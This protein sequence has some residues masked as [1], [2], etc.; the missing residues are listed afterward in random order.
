M[1]MGSKTLKQKSILI[2]G[3]SSE[4]LNVLLKDNTTGSNIIWA[5]VADRVKNSF[6]DY[7]IILKHLWSVIDS[8]PLLKSLITKENLCIG[9][10]GKIIPSILNA[11]ISEED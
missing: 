11:L 8:N 7:I 6:D 9:F 1:T 5:K 10:D 3:I 4:I 2:N